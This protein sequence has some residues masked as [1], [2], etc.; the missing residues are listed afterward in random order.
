MIVLP[1]HIKSFMLCAYV[2]GQR[3]RERERSH[4]QRNNEA[5]DNDEDLLSR[6]KEKG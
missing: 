5:V 6:S 4:S 1:H 2:V 3:Q